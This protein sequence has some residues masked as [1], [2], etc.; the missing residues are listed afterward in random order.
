MRVC[1]IGGTL[2]IGR[3]LVEKLLGV[4]TNRNLNVIRTLADKWG[5]TRSR[6]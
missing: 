1:V 5:G 3:A 4:A 6:K 2:F